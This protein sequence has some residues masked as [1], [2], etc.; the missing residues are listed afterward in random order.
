MSGAFK[1]WRPFV[2]WLRVDGANY[3]LMYFGVPIGTGALAWLTGF[4]FPHVDPLLTGM[5][6]FAG[7]LV[8]LQLQVLGWVA[9]AVAQLDR[10]GR[11]D[12]YQLD[13]ARRFVDATERL[14][15]SLTWAAVV[16]IALVIGLMLT[17][18]LTAGDALTT[19]WSVGLSVVGTHLVMLI[20]AIA[21]RVS[22]VTSSMLQRRNG[23][24]TG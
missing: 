4:G 7:T 15:H 2:A 20:V 5:V 1:I 9:D 10:P 8:A 12:A 6:F 11:L 19:P 13:R 21:N 3:P 18:E 22:Y 24:P 17:P 16:S 23:T 14:Y